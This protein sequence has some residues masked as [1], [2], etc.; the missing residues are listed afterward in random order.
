[1]WSIETLETIWFCQL[2]ISHWPCPVCSRVVQNGLKLFKW[3]HA[4][5][6][7][8]LWHHISF[9]Y[10][11]TVNFCKSIDLNCSKH[12]LLSF[13]FTLMGKKVYCTCTFE[14]KLVKMHLTSGLPQRFMKATTI[15]S[16][17]Y[18]S[19]VIGWQAFYPMPLPK[20]ECN[21]CDR[22]PCIFGSEVFYFPC[23]QRTSTCAWK[24]GICFSFLFCFLYPFFQKASYRKTS[25]RGA[26]GHDPFWSVFEEYPL[27]STRSDSTM[28]LF[29]I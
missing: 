10:D 13:L 22:T 28:T 11:F 2:C 6:D 18:T 23:Q 19:Q 7:I 25:S 15:S 14:G 3:T 26:Y 27:D 20:G 16:P 9:H 4:L 21:G 1:M 5:H 8:G 29:I 17:A 24:S 12:A